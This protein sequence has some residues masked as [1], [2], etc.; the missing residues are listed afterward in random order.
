[1]TRLESRRN[2]RAQARGEIGVA[3]SFPPPAA[4]GPGRSRRAARPASPP[5]RPDRGRCSDRRGDRAVRAGLLEEATTIGARAGWADRLR[6]RGYAL[7]GH[8]LVRGAGTGTQRDGPGRP[9][10]GF[11]PGPTARPAGIAVGPVRPSADWSWWW[12]PRGPVR[13]GSG[14]RPIGR[15][16][17]PG[18]DRT[19]GCGSGGHFLRGRRPVPC[20]TRLGGR[21]PLRLR[22]EWLSGPVG[23]SGRARHGPGP[24]GSG[25]GVRAVAGPGPGGGW[26]AAARAE[27]A[28]PRSTRRAPA[29]SEPF[30]VPP[31]VRS[32][33]PAP[34]ASL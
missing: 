33:S 4:R 30:A 14:R 1:M 6:E 15:R 17:A 32:R 21:G 16:S 27:P 25:V 19:N 2:A 23:L 8:R 28:T 7:C 26:A 5:G 24:G 11:R 22:G 34:A 20:R 3:A 13:P 10:T 31:R 18:P 12:P 29:R 9:L